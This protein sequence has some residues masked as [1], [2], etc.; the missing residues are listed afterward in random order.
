MSL[1]RLAGRVRRIVRDNIGPWIRSGSVVPRFV[2]IYGRM[3]DQVSVISTVCR[4]MGY[5]MTEARWVP[6]SMAFRSFTT[7]RYTPDYFGARFNRY[8]VFNLRNVT[9]NKEFVQSTFETVFGYPL[10]VDPVTYEGP[11]MR[12]NN[13]NAVKDN[14]IVQCPIPASEL[15]PGQVYELLVDTSTPEGWFVDHRVVVVGDQFPLAYLKY[16][17]AHDRYKSQVKATVELMSDLFD[18]HEI[19][20]LRRFC[21]ECRLDFGEIDV[22]RDNT[23]GRIYAVDI[24]NNAGRF[25]KLLTPSDRAFAVNT[26]ADHLAEHIRSG[27]LPQKEWNG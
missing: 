18:V 3:P 6:W 11:C 7:N 12:K 22:L 26:I 19:E 21:R 17:P 25:S 4:H 9:L 27:K 1:Q 14:T 20:R 15:L 13:R 24:T 16:H 23:S 2:L 8:P 5:Q 10:R